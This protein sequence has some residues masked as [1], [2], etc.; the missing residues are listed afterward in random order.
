MKLIIVGAGGHAK[1]AFD[2]VRKQ[3]KY[4]PVV[5]IDELNYGHTMC[6]IEV[7]KEIKHAEDMFFIVAIGDNNVRKKKYEHGLSLG[8]EP[9]IVVHPGAIIA[10]D[11]SVGRGSVIFAGAI[12]NAGATIGENSIINTSATIDHDCHLAAHVH[13]APGC[14]LAGE[15][16]VG[17]GS[18]FGIGSVAIPKTTVGKWAITGAGAVIVDDV[19]DGDTVVGVPARVFR[20][21]RSSVS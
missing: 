11:V 21:N 19:A 6:G 17:E 14:H 5:F 15:I 1:V 12:I 7:K 4:E 13:I 16:T 20:K 2:A 3:G 18:L 9:A 10:Q 8:W